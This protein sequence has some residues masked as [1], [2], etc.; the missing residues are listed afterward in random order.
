MTVERKVLIFVVSTLLVA[1][2]IF[3]LLRK[4][5]SEEPDT[6]GKYKRPL[7]VE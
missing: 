3:C 4:P 1:A 6:T 5:P 7:P 2:I